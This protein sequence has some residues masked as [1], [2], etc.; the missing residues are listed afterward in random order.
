MS[1]IDAQLY[2]TGGIWEI[3]G[4]AIGWPIGYLGEDGWESW[5]EAAEVYLRRAKK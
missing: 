4:R 5:D 3:I 2:R 1:G